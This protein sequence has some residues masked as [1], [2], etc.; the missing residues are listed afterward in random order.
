MHVLLG[1]REDYIYI[2]IYFYIYIF[3]TNV[4]N[5]CTV[6]LL[7]MGKSGGTDESRPT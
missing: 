1:K 2:S 4:G 5:D 6:R 3:S 7:G